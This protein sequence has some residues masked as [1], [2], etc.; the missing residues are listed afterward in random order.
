MTAIGKIV[1]LFS[2]YREL[3]FALSSQNGISTTILGLDSSNKL[4]GIMK[5]SY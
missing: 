5:S 1:K 4:G 3:F 2:K